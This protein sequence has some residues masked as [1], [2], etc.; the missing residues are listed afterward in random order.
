MTKPDLTAALTLSDP[1]ATKRLYKDWAATY[2][3]EFAKNMEYRLPIQ[4]AANFITAGGQGPVL[5]IGAGT[6]LLAQGLRE[7]GF[8]GQI[9]GLDFSGEMLA[10]ATEKHIYTGLF[11]A[12]VTE[13]LP[14]KR[15]YNGITSSGTFTAGHVGPAAFGPMLAVALPGALFA[16]S[17]NQRVWTELSF[18]LALNDLL[19]GGEIRDLELVEVDVYGAAAQS[20]DPDHAGDR[21]YI[22]LFHAA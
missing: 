3:S 8:E 19:D 1:Q 9:D 11:R 4:V 5:D 14:L 12:D 22:A 20:M 10:R 21:A 16:L 18:D 15:I 17:I 7:M 13:E 6:G 2:D